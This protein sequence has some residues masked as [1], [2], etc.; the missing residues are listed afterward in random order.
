MYVA[1]DHEF[2]S[3]EDEYEDEDGFD[4]DEEQRI[5]PML[6]VDSRVQKKI[7]SFC[8]LGIILSEV[9]VLLGSRLRVMDPKSRC[10]TNLGNL[11]SVPRFSDTSVLSHPRYIGTLCLVTT[12]IHNIIHE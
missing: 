12:T 8:S 2:D 6:I 11:F 1:S 4:E 5:D 7:G 10:W 9:R 3:D